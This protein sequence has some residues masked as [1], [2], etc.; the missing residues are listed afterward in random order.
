MSIV[1]IDPLFQLIH[2]L[3]CLF[4]RHNDNLCRHTG[5]VPDAGIVDGVEPENV[6]LV[7][8]GEAGGHH[9]AGT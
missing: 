5:E 7:H 2:C 1:S 6:P 8:P 4:V 3:H 9:T